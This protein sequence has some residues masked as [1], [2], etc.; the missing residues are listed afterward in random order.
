MYMFFILNFFMPDEYSYLHLSFSPFL[1]PPLVFATKFFILRENRESK[2]Y[3]H[4]EKEDRESE[5]TYLRVMSERVMIRGIE[6]P[7]KRLMD[8]VS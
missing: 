8:K 2:T 4:G 6:G 7:L 5:M 1:S 3:P